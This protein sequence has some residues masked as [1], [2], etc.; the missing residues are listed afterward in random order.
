MSKGDFRAADQAAKL[1]VLSDITT[2]RVNMAIG[3]VIAL[4]RAGLHDPSADVRMSALGAVMGRAMAARW[5]GTSGPGMWPSPTRRPEPPIIPAEWKG[6]QQVL[7]D[8]LEDDCLALLKSDSDDRVRYQ[9]L[10]AVGNLE[11][12]TQPDDPLPERL[13]ALF[14]GLYRHDLSARIRAEVVKTFRHVPNNTPEMRAVLRDALVDTNATIRHEGLTGITPQATA[15]S[16]RLSFDEARD[17][18]VT[19]LK[20]AD[21][22]I[23]LGAVQALNVFGA[24]AAPYIQTLERLSAID[25]DAQVR[26]SARL[27]I[28]AIQRVLRGPGE[29]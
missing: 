16:R 8:A 23:R 14:V 7:R 1:R 24:P 10:L 18:I 5:A 11:R 3:Q 29:S 17:T 28:E 2:A 21:P 9:A 4:V 15:V 6:D 13:V 20:H 25:P 26:A 19:A 27:A 22:G 12:P